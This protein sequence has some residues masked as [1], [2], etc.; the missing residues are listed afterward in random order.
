MLH[1]AL[2]YE[3]PRGMFWAVGTDQRALP[4]SWFVYYV[5]CFRMELFFLLAGYFSQFTIERRGVRAFLQDRIRRVGLVFLIVLIP[6]KY[7]ITWLWIRGGLQSGTLELPAEAAGYPP[8]VVAIG[9]L[10]ND[11]WPN[12]RIGHL[13]FLYYLILMTAVYAGAVAVR[14]HWRKRT[15]RLVG[16]RRMIDA[17]LSPLLIF[18]F[19]SP[20]LS[21]MLGVEVDTPMRPLPIEPAVMAVYGL[22]FLFGAWLRTEHDLL[23]RVG[24]HWRICLPL[25]LLVSGLGV[26]VWGIH[27]GIGVI[28][29]APDPRLRS[30]GI[31]V[32]AGTMAFAVPGWLGL[33][34]HCF[35]HPSRAVRF[36]ADSSYWVYLVHLPVVVTFQIWMY[37]W[38]WPWW[39]RWPLINLLA[40]PILIGS[41]WMIRNTW[42]GRLMQGRPASLNVPQEPKS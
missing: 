13:W 8:S 15:W 27:L 22:F 40:A 39:I 10:L 24:R 1:A 34:L 6:I 41:Y 4:L 37:D 16:L 30:I 28:T 14:R 2:A 18:A 5:H 3:L 42:F 7:A 26:V 35:A 19:A 12:V 23:S 25:S 33:F 38:P 21:T 11:S 17:G 32:T 36:L 31:A 9:A 29:E 20:L